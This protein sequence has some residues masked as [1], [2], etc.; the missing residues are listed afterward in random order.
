M[1]HGTDRDGQ[2]TVLDVGRSHRLVTDRQYRALLLRDGGCGFPGCGST[3]G[4]EAHHVKHWLYG[5]RT[6]LANLLVL[7]RRHHHAHHDGEFTITPRRRGRFRFTRADGQVLPLRHDPSVEV[8][9]SPP[10]EDEHPRV[11]AG[12]ATPR[13]DG[14]RLDL[15]YAVHAIAQV[16]KRPGTMVG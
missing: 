9:T 12:A 4:L 15:D 3:D 8:A 10:I 11:P 2:S 7:Y 6:D 16:L 14:T 5:G 1:L 13:W